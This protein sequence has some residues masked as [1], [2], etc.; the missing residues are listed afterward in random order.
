MGNNAL[1]YLASLSLMPL[2]VVLG[3]AL[4]AGAR[5][6]RCSRVRQIGT[7]FGRIGIHHF[8]LVTG[9]HRAFMLWFRF[10]I[11]GS[12]NDGQQADAKDGDGLFHDGDLV[13]A[14]K[15]PRLSQLLS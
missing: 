13:V 9:T 8:G 1:L 3:S 12:N 6:T 7:G 2:A 15:L 11:A 5:S 4:D 14:D 10:W